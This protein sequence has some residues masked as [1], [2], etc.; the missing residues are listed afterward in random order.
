ML[1]QWPLWLPHVSW[2][3]TV[4]QAPLQLSRIL[5]D[6][7]FSSS[8]PGPLSALFVALISPMRQKLSVHPSF[9]LL[10]AGVYT[11][12][13]T[14][15]LWIWVTKVVFSKCSS[16]ARTFF[17]KGSSVLFWNWSIRN[18]GFCFWGFR[19]SSL[20]RF[21]NITRK[22]PEKNLC[23]LNNFDYSISQLK[24]FYFISS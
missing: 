22:I 17:F 1:L 2:Q 3:D 20:I 4:R 19:Y 24:L 16:G 21:E 15:P 7:L 10:D 23:V 13:Q 11:H 18:N 8:T 14:K 5:S 9:T 6:K 12:R